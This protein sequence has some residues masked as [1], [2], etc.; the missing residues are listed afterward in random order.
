MTNSTEIISR[1]ERY[2]DTDSA[3]AMLTGAGF[4]LRNLGII[5]D[6][7]RAEFTIAGLTRAGDRI[8]R[9]SMCAAFCGA[10]VAFVSG[11]VFTPLSISGS[12]LVLDYLATIVVYI[13]EGAVT[14]G[15]LGLVCAMA[16]NSVERKSGI[17]PLDRILRA[18]NFLL[19]A[20][21]TP[22]QNARAKSLVAFGNR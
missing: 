21:G 1:F 16:N 7:Y 20:R 4:S 13:I 2:P 15:A 14:G 8:K 18:E 12:V 3:V 11:A 19:V 10:A 6:E 9:W 17:I 5:G 22:E